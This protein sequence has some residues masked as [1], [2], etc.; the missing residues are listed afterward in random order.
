MDQVVMGPNNTLIFS[1]LNVGNYR[2]MKPSTS[3][4]I[5]TT[6]FQDFVIDSGGQ[7]LIVTA[8]ESAYF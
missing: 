5:N 7:D 4:V 1:V 8:N 6:D 2:S 3:F